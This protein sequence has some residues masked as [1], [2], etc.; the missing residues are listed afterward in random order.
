[1]FKAEVAKVR[2]EESRL[3]KATAA[4]FEQNRLQVINEVEQ[5]VRQIKEKQ[6]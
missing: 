1:M 2:A 6:T 4:F 5:V 3:S